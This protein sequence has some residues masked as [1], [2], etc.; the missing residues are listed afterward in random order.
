[1]IVVG[2]DPHKASHTACALSAGSGELLEERRVPA[3]GQGQLLLLAWARGLGGQ[4]LW[5]IEDC[6]H[7]SRG[8]E[9]FLLLAGERVVRVAP[10]LTARERRRGRRLGKSDRV[11][12]LAAARAALSEPGLPAARLEGPERELAL[13]VDYR[14]QLVAE[15]TRCASRLRWLVHE[16]ELGLEIPAGALDR[17][18]WLERLEQALVA[19]PEATLVLIS[20]ALLARLCEL[21]EQ[22]NALERQLKPLVEALAAPLLTQP[23]CGALTAAKIIS[24]IAGIERFP[25]ESKLAMHAGC[26]PLEASSGSRHRHRLNRSGNR[27]LNCALHRMAVAQGR[28]HPPARAYLARRQQEGK[29]RREALRCLKRQLV[30]VV[31]RALTQTTTTPTRPHRAP[32]NLT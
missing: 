31:Y 13:L 22:I 26:A 21:R 15:R 12:A 30:R 25:D 7:V 14:E 29:T 23:G 24:E 3:D 2:L 1:M 28:F 9:R 5:A 18:C 20:R 27:Q 8:L 10:R 11:D 19:L 6:R 32:P 17:R 4:R 16:L